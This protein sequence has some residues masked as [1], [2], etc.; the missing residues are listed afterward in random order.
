MNIASWKLSGCVELV[1]LSGGSVSSATQVDPTELD[2]CQN[3]ST[4]L[5]IVQKYLECSRA[6]GNRDIRNNCGI[7]THHVWRKVCDLASRMI[8]GFIYH[9]QLQVN[10]DFLLLVLSG[11]SNNHE[12]VISKDDYDAFINAEEFWEQK[13][14]NTCKPF[15]ELDI[16]S[17]LEGTA[18]YDSNAIT[19]SSFYDG[20]DYKTIDIKTPGEAYTYQYFQDEDNASE[21]NDTGNKDD[22]E[23][24]RG[25]ESDTSDLEIVNATIVDNRKL[26]GNNVNKRKSTSDNIDESNILSSRRE[27]IPTN[28]FVSPTSQVR[29]RKRTKKAAKGSSGNSST[30][31]RPKR[32]KSVR[33]GSNSDNGD[34]NVNNDG[35]D[36]I[37][38]D[39]D[40]TPDSAVSNDNVVDG[41]STNDSNSAGSGSGEV[42]NNSP[43]IIGSDKTDSND[44]I[45]K[46]NNMTSG[47]N[48]DGGSSS[49]IVGNS[50]VDNDNGS[51]IVNN[52]TS[53][54]GNDVVSDNTSSSI[55]GNPYRQA[56][57]DLAC[58]SHFL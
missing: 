33:K 17:A 16:V 47:D 56:L 58:S 15:L 48:A 45:V 55:D 52:S 44:K 30:N 41:K 46:D 43:N 21:E 11:D 31:K 34:D 19:N 25:A 32:G 14:F 35:D 49:A 51:G 50:T 22:I 3:L 36:N 28:R 9:N 54:N 42:V 2:P 5:K 12:R 37:D 38:A 10:Q 8:V 40:A 18:N 13:Q 24:D 57:R 26:A 29:K 4:L 27:S 7:L 1:A 6:Q 20:I 53:D 39:D 23:T